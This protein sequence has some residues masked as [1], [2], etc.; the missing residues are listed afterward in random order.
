MFERF[1]QQAR[2][3]IVLAQEQARALE[4]DSIGTEHLLLGLLEEEDGAAVHVLEGL[5]V[6]AER[7]RAEVAR[8]RA[9]GRAT[10][11]Q[12]PFTA[13][14][15]EVLAGALREAL[16]LG[17]DHIGTEHLLLGVLSQNA[18][19]ATRILRGLGVDPGKVRGEVA[20]TVAGLVE[21]EGSPPATD[22]SDAELDELIDQLV[23]ERH[24]LTR[25]QRVVEGTLAGLRSERDARR[26]R[27][28]EPES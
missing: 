26:R 28:S 18:A 27:A 5:G 4:H 25:R 24:T 22:L 1:T 11:G 9:A 20:R 7:V 10:S 21:H 6:T 15:K 2:D 13:R 14:A 3:V 16:S 12:I 17:H 19:V 23:A 8:T